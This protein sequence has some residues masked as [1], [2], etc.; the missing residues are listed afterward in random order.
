MRWVAISSVMKLLKPILIAIGIAP[1][2]CLLL[3]LPMLGIL[4]ASAGAIGG[5]LLL[6]FLIV[7]QWPMFRLFQRYLPTRDPE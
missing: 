3:A 7:L 1:L 2:L 5:F 4:H 6:A